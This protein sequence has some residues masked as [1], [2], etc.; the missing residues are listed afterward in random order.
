[1]AEFKKRNL[2]SETFKEF[3]EGLA[4]QIKSSEKKYGFI[5]GIPRGGSVVGVYLSHILDIPFM[6]YSEYFDLREHFIDID[7]DEPSRVLF[8]DDIADTGMTLSLIDDATKIDYAPWD[9]ATLF[10]K[11]RSSVKPTFF[12]KEISDDTWVIFPWEK[13]SEIPNREI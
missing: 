6:E 12:H 13:D 4:E 9:T 3:C 2:N 1:M 11:T 10:Y 7:E 5:V 8:I